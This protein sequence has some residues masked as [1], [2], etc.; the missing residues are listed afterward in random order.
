MYWG[1]IDPEG[2][3]STN[4]I[5]LQGRLKIC[6]QFIDLLVYEPGASNHLFGLR[7]P[8][9]QLSKQ[10]DMLGG[11]ME[12]GAYR[13]CAACA[14]PRSE[15]G[16]QRARVRSCGRGTGLRQPSE[17]RAGWLCAEVGGHVGQGARAQLPRQHRCAGAAV[18]A[19]PA[20]HGWP[21]G[22]PGPLWQGKVESDF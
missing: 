21:Q 3:R 1:V 13:P 8:S 17:G 10:T 14:R 19:A 4:N 22:P 7:T 6:D 16:G 5:L 20:E 11:S 9:H 12:D 15:G 2:G 18:A